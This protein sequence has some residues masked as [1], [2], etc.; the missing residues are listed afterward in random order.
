MATLRFPL[1][2]LAIGALAALALAAC[3]SMPPWP[4]SKSEAAAP[5]DQQVSAAPNG[6]ENIAPQA[7]TPPAARTTTTP[8]LTS[9]VAAPIAPP[10]APDEIVPPKPSPTVVWVPGYWSFDGTN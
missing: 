8:P 7:G 3:S 2:G 5:S 4:W 9:V 10:P 6:L 1:S